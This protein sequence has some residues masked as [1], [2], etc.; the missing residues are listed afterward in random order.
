MAYV[1]FGESLV[2]M[3]LAGMVIVMAAVAIATRIPA[4]D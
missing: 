4:R 2:P 3:Q 1:L